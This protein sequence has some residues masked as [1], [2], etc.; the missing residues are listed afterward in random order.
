[1][2]NTYLKIAWRNILKHKLYSG[3]NIIGLS[4]G[5]AASLLIGVYIKSELSYD[6]F[7]AYGRPYSNKDAHLGKVLLG[8]R[9][10][11]IET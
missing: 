3:I 2:Y 10:W 4:I 1:M 6:L 5:I 9:Y 11:K 8:V 7:H